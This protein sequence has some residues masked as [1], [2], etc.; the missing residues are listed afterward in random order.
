VTAESLRQRTVLVTREEPDDGPLT[1]ALVARGATVRRV[2]L[3]ET[4]PPEDASDLA[5]AASRIA[6]FDW[7]VVT[8]AR[9]VEALAEAAG[10]GATP[11]IAAVG[12]G[13]ARAV[14]NVGWE[15][16]VIGTGGAVALAQ[17][18]DDR[19]GLE[20]SSVLF[21]AADRA[22]P[23]TA[24]WLREAGALVCVVTAY[25]TVAREGAAAEL[26]AALAAT[27]LDAA[28]F[29]SPSAVDVLVEAADVPALRIRLG[30]IGPTTRA[31]LEAAGAYDLVTP[32]QP[33][34][35]AL[36][37]ALARALGPG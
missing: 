7:V 13:T 12:E 6:D 22:R 36:A 4:R 14:R 15:P 35:E 37:Q 32:A 19:K 25:R 1:T 16:S 17:A 21:P 10:T 8:S 27:D 11:R 29:T 3:L 2:P 30:A 20:G 18:F 31:R 34:F 26:A 28:V 23:E 24:Q 9:A 33:T 5:E